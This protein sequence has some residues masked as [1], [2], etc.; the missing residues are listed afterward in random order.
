MNRHKITLNYLLF[1][2]I[3]V[4]LIGIIL[5]SSLSRVIINETINTTEATVSGSGRYLE[6]YLDRIKGLSNI[7][8]KNQDVIHYF[9]DDEGA[10]CVSNE[11]AITSFVNNLVDSDD[12]IESVIL[13]SKDGELFSNEEELDMKMSEDMMK[14]EWYV[15]AIASEMPVLTSARMQKFSMDKDLWVISMSQEIVDAEGNNIGVVLIDIPYTVIEGFLTKVDFGNTGYAFIINDYDEVVFHEDVSY[16]TDDILKEGLITYS[17]MTEGYMSDSNQVLTRYEFENANWT[18][19]ALCSLD[20]LVIVKRQLIETIIFGSLAIFVG[21]L[22]TSWILRNLTKEIKNKET[23]IHKFQMNALMSQINPHFLYNTLDTIVWMAEFNQKEEVIEITKSLAGFFRL[24]LNGGNDLTSLEDELEHVKKYLY[25]QKQRYQDKLNYTFIV[26]VKLENQL[27]DFFVPKIILQPI[28]ENAIYHGI[29]DMEGDG[30]ITI[31]VLA[32][33]GLDY[34]IQVRDNGLG[35][36]MNS[37]TK[38]LPETNKLKLGGVGLLNV[39]RRIQLL[40]GEPY[41]IEIKSELNIGTEVTL[42]LKQKG[43]I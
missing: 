2:L 41:G 29:K 17:R 27:K 43:D 38:E 16:Y 35:Y 32:G 28:V 40:Y 20:S 13:I 34:T 5:Y 37:E 30:E 4:S 22:V 1:G 19:V 39:Q 10:R 42:K 7:V 15:K 26:D 23:E 18:L 3:S 14:E 24:S 31:E 6:A 8:S 33:K 36:K 9:S 21:V 25:I 12:T 11:S